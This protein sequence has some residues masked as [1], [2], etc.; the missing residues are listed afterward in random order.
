MF[1]KLLFTLGVIL[2]VVLVVRGQPRPPTEA[3]KPPPPRRAKPKAA[4]A[5]TTAWILVG[6]FVTLTLGYSAWQWLGSRDLVTVRV[7]NSNNG[8]SVA[9]R[10]YRGEVGDHGFTTIDGRAITLARIERMEVTRPAL[11]K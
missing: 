1:T 8:S 10:A 7:I 11:R 6:V 4:S 9:Y 2:V 3:A 5:R